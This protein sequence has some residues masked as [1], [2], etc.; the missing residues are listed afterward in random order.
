MIEISLKILNGK[1]MVYSLQ[2]EEINEK[3]NIE[4]QDKTIKKKINK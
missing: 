2:K 3:I 4:L 1:N